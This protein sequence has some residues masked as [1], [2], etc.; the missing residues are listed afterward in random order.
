MC[1]ILSRLVYD[2]QV[3]FCDYYK[4]GK[5]MMPSVLKSVQICSVLMKSKLTLFILLTHIASLE[6][7]N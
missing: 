5:F 7:N 4:V 1:V 6:V 2:G 3:F